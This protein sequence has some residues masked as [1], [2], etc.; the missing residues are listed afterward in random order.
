MTSQ[1][2]VFDVNHQEQHL[3]ELLA[4]GGEGEVYPLANRKDVLVKLYHPEQLQK[5]GAE[6]EKKVEAMRAVS[7][8]RQQKGVSWPLI[9]AY[10]AN[11]RWIGYA[12]YRAQGKPMFYLA[13][14]LLYKKHFPGLDR[15]GLVDYLIQLVQHLRVLHSQGVMV[16]DYNLHNI[17]CDPGSDEVTLIDC[18]SYQIQVNGQHYPNPVGSADLTPK[19]HQGKSFSSLVRTPESEAFSLAIIFFK[20]LVLGRHPYDIVG[21]EDPVTNLKRGNFAYGIGNKGIPKG[22]WYNIW[23][24]MPHRLKSLFI[25]TFTEGADDPSKR[26]TPVEWLEALRRYRKEMDKGWHETAIRPS[27]PKSNTYRGNSQ[28]ATHS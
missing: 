6:L 9:S 20:C 10:D 18:D 27:A 21:G 16:G 14:A 2:H 25:Q 1:R 19:E 22:D 28:S 8:L 13:H 5:R 26:A 17:L 12:M 24:H 15:R 7:Q 23:S 4:K 3:G 11:Q